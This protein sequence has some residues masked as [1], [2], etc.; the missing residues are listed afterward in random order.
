MTNN[1]WYE[2][3]N[4]GKESSFSALLLSRPKRFDCGTLKQ[5]GSDYN[6]FGAEVKSQICSL[7]C[8]TP[9]QLMALSFSPECSNVVTAVVQCHCHGGLGVRLVAEAKPKGDK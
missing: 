6:M 2:L 7:A 3:A 9:S 1:G 8:L 5:Q 4:P